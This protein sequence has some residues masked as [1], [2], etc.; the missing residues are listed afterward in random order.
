MGAVANLVLGIGDNRAATYVGNVTGPSSGRST[1]DRTKRRTPRRADSIRS[2]ADGIEEK[3][4]F[5]VLSGTKAAGLLG[6]AT[7]SFRTLKT[8]WSIGEDATNSA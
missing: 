1:L 2:H 5:N 6:C 4:Y 8:R 3:G 7:A